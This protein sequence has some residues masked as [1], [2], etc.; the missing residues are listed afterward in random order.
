VISTEKFQEIKPYIKLSSVPT[1]KRDTQQEKTDFSKIDLNGITFRQLLEFGLDEKSAGSIIGF[2]KKLGAL[3][4]NNRY[5]TRI[6][7]IR[8][9]FRS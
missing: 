3:S 8:K 2:R 4:R 1:K 7:L 6:I 9:W 5:S